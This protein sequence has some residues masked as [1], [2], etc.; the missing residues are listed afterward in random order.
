MSKVKYNVQLNWNTLSQLA[1]LKLG[2]FLTITIWKNFGGKKLWQMDRIGRGKNSFF[3]YANVSMCQRSMRW[4]HG[5]IKT[6]AVRIETNV[7]LVQSSC[8]SLF[9]DG[10]SLM[11]H[12]RPFGSH[13]HPWGTLL[14]CFQKDIPQ[15]YCHSKQHGRSWNGTM[16]NEQSKLLVK[17]TLANYYLFTKVFFQHWRDVLYTSSVIIDRLSPFGVL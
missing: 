15:T 9:R 17:Q 4:R 11:W 3:S 8:T 7:I 14:K 12:T 6:C 5:T 16:N 10:H 1:K 2:H 13:L